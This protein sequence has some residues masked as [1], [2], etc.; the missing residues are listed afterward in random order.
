L[1]NAALSCEAID[2]P[3]GVCNW[4][5]VL[6]NAID[7]SLAFASR[8]LSNAFIVG[9]GKHGAELGERSYAGRRR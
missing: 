2:H 3:F 6:D 8:R 9:D 1:A 7:P 5:S 4:A